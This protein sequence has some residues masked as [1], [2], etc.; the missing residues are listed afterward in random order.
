VVPRIVHLAPGRQWRGGERQVWL[1]AS[2]LR[3]QGVDQTVITDRNGRL[4]RELAEA[5][6]PTRAVSWRAA[7]SP[8][9]AIAAV[10]EARRRPAL[11]HAHDPHAVIIAGVVAR[12]LRLPFVATRRVDLPLRRS[13][14]W[15]RADRIIAISEAV[16]ATLLG[17]GIEP[18]RVAVVPSGVDLS[19]IRPA[20][21]ATAP[22]RLVN[23]GAL[24]PEKNHR[25]LLATAAR[26][27]PR[28][29]DLRWTIAGQGPLEGDLVREAKRLGVGHAVAFRS[30]FTDP[31]EVLAGATALVSCSTSE[32]LGTAIL[33]AMA[34]GVPVVA[35]AVGG[36]PELLAG[37]AGL[38][39]P[40]GD[41]EALA[42]AIETLLCD[43]TSRQGVIVKA[44]ETVQGYRI[45]RMAS[46]VLDVYRSV[47]DER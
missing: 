37:G 18:S 42:P 41:P 26:L 19:R 16:R 34:A 14:F 30:E 32:G 21:P 25:L 20:G 29:P 43:E 33:E 24:T 40:Q 17:S 28:Y 44:M 6:V 46:Q 3:D 10:L 5:G 39:V 45:G 22:A 7:L 9:A 47:A 15:A 2:A 38:L 31:A 13:G 36:I 4:A 8:A 27:A 12:L 11:L 23:I 35:V 1:L